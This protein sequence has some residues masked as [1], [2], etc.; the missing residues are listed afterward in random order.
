MK[1]RFFLP[2]AAVSALAALTLTVAAC[3]G[4]QSSTP[5]PTVPAGAVEIE[6]VPGLKFD[7]ADYTATAGSVTI[8]Y[9]NLDTMR[10]TLVITDANGIVIGNKLEVNKKNDLSTGTFDLA[11]GTYTVHCDVPGHGSMKATLVVS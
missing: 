10:H 8:A 2:A 5:P 6:A 1:A 4:S 7:K 11:P 9:V 3:G